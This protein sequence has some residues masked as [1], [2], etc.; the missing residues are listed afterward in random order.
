MYTR[1]L[2]VVD[3]KQ[4]NGCE[5]QPFFYFLIAQNNASNQPIPVHPNTHDATRTRSA[6]NLSLPFLAAKYA[7]ANIMHTNTMAATMYFAI[8]MYSALICIAIYFPYV[9][10]LPNSSSIRNNW[11]YFAMR[12]VRDIEPV[13]I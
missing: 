2:I 12:S 8:K 1:L 11:L 3:A 7:G 13:L 4:K 5:K 6:I 10:L 9:A